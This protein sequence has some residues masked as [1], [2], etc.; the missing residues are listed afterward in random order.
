MNEKCDTVGSGETSSDYD[1]FFAER[2]L[3]LPVFPRTENSMT[4]IFNV[5]SGKSVGFDTTRR[6]DP[7]FSKPDE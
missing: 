2:R 4:L 1:F 5:P 3:N 7:S 6:G